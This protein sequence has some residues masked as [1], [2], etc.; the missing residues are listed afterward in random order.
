ML[1]TV[2]FSTP[3][4]Y[5]FLFLVSRSIRWY[6]GHDYTGW[7][8]SPLKQEVP[9]YL[10]KCWDPHPKNHTYSCFLCQW[11]S[12]GMLQWYCFGFKSLM[13]CRSWPYGLVPSPLNRRCSNTLKTVEI[14]THKPY[15]FLFLVA[16]SIRWYVGHD[17]TGWSR[18]PLNRKCPNIWKSVEIPTLKP[19]VFLLFFFFLCQW[20]SDGI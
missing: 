12:D 17:H 13:V 18:S 3:K 2:E 16:R 11:T 19:H 10:E 1:E 15:I 6:I 5:I 14:L 8:L 20:T 4:L 9:K 7:L